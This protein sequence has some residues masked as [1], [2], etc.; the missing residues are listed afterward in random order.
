MTRPNRTFALVVLDRLHDVGNEL[1]KELRPHDPEGRSFS[2]GVCMWVGTVLATIP[3]QHREEFCE[4]AMGY[5]LIVNDLL[6]ELK[7]GKKS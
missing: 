2:L 7:R 4:G 5:A 6:D 3:E 1:M